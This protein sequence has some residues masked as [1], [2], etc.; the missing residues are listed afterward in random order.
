MK[1]FLSNITNQVLIA[2]VL[3]VIAGILL[4]DM[5]GNVKFIGDIFLRLIQMSVVVLVMGAVIEAVGSLEPKEL[6]KMGAKVFAWFMGSTILAAALGIILGLVI[7]PGEGIDTSAFDVEVIET[8]SQTVFETITAF[9]PTN[10]IQAMADANMI[11]VIIFAILFGLALGLIKDEGKN[12]IL[13]DFIT[14]FNNTILKMITMIMKLAPIGVFCLI[15]PVIGQVGIAVL[16]TLAKFLMAFGIGTFLFLTIWIFITAVY[17]KVSPVKL[18]QNMWRMTIVALTTTSSAVTLPV[19]LEDGKNKLGISDRISKFVIPLGMSLNSN[20]LAMFLSLA[21][22]T[23]AQFYGIPMGLGNLVNA[24]I[25]STLATL[26]TVVVPGGGLVALAMVMPA[27]GLPTES[28]AILAGI[29]WFSGMFRTVLNVDA[30]TTVALI[31]AKDEDELDYDV[32]R[33]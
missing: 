32:F 24:V 22:V 11:Q 14:A 12:S 19:Q 16:L 33:A 4:P 15:A 26:G 9:F 31:I 28:I 3:G 29:D 27:L 7:Q 6:G 30:D 13:I 1:K 20:G 21:I 25:L 8:S 2:T 23:F 17:C 5:M 10:V 18:A